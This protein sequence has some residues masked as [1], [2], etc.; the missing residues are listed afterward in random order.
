MATCVPSAWMWSF[1]NT[2][3]SKLVG[4]EE[5]ALY[6]IPSNVGLNGGQPV[7]QPVDLSVSLGDIFK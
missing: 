2:R 4:L 5:P 1:L 7:N 3:S 6:H